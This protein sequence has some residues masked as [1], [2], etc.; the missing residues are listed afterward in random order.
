MRVTYD[1]E[2]DASYIYLRAIEPGG[3]KTTVPV[4]EAEGV[5]AGNL[6]LDFDADGRLIGIEVLCASR[7]L[8]CE[9]LAEAE[10]S[11]DIQQR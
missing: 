1:P 10:R 8:P 11:R 7:V 5:A 9:L 2:V 6:I 4:R 3:S